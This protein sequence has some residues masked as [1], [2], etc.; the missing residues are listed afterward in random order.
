M[1]ALGGAPGVHSAYYAG[2]E[3]NRAERDARNNLKLLADLKDE[4]NRGAHYACVMV[5][6]RG[7]G[8]SHPLVAEARWE[9]EI[10]QAPR[11]TGGFGYDPLFLPRGRD[12]TA[13]E[14]A[15]EEK[16]RLSHRGRALSKLL[17]LIRSSA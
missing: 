10:A 9:G 17:E 13:A 7:P 15:P 12:C 6:V 4:A 1:D 3:G 14:L 5:L 8:D 2:R 11:G 16:N